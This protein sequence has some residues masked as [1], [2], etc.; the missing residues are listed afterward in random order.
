MSSQMQ[1][2]LL[3]L[4]R[5]SVRTFRN[6][7]FLFGSNSGSSTTFSS[8]FWGIP[9]CLAPNLGQQDKVVKQML[10]FAPEPVPLIH[11]FDP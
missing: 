2:T 8:T 4:R 10:A 11:V 6:N 7:P 3:S 9:R 1:K 5:H